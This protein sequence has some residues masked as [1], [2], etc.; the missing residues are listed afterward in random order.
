M[1]LTPHI[2][3]STEEAQENIAEFV[4]TKIIDFINN[5]NSVFSV[6]FPEIKLPSF[7]NAHRLIH[8]HENVPGILAQINTVFS[9]RN[10]NIIGQ[11]LKTNEK[12]GYVITDISKKYNPEL[13]N[14]LK[15]IKH[16]IKF[17]VLY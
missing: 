13:I 10:I 12:I 9:K 1:I 17:R 6:N 15:N 4:P 5:G 2:A 11:Y 8:I 3:G 14:D 7:E 16:T